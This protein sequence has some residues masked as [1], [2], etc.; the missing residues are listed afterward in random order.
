MS[1][2][3]AG[4]SASVS[5]YCCRCWLCSVARDSGG[6]IGIVHCFVACQNH[7]VVDG[8]T[9]WNKEIMCTLR[10]ERHES[11]IAISG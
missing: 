7:S 5:I 11:F 3:S 10:S 2:G 8:G 9:L 6:A 4:G 1:V